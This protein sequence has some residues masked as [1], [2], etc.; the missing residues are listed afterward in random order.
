MNELD[1]G[2]LLSC[3]EE[4][5]LALLAD[6]FTNAEI[7]EQLVCSPETVK[8]HVSHILTKLGLGS[9]AKRRDGGA[10]RSP[11]TGDGQLHHSKTIMVRPEVPTMRSLQGRRDQRGI[12]MLAALAEALAVVAVAI[13]QGVG[14]S[15]P[16]DDQPNR[17][18]IAYQ[19]VHAPS[20]TTS[21]TPTGIAQEP[22]RGLAE[23]VATAATLNVTSWASTSDPGVSLAVSVPPTFTAKLRVLNLAIGSGQVHE[24][25][26]TNPAAA[27]RPPLNEGAPVP[28]GELSLTV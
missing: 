24:L 27:S 9:V 6:D 23:L 2:R 11:V 21:P 12:L 20:T 3:T 14:G 25:V 10:K 19:T 17:P 13:G 22:L 18:A 28:P 4:R 26:V 7:A 5:V 8:T 16:A 1:E 15:G